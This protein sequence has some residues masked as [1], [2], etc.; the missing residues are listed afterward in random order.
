M[1]NG[2]SFDWHEP[3]LTIGQ[4]ARRSGV[5]ASAIR[6]YEAQGL[7]SSDRTAGNQRRYHG[8]VMCRLAMIEACQRVGLTLAEVGQALAALPSGRAPNRQ[9]WDSLAERL[10][11]E[12]QSRIDQLSQVLGELAPSAEPD[13]PEPD[14]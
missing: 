11:T 9:D 10:R 8:D 5:A 7:V 1:Q 12:A 4:V 3:G 2:M 6:F 13:P 14:A